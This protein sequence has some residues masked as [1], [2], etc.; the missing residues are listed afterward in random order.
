[1]SCTY[2][3]IHIAKKKMRLK[4]TNSCLSFVTTLWRNEVI[5]LCFNNLS[6]KIISTFCNQVMDS[7]DL[8]ELELITSEFIFFSY[9]NYYNLTKPI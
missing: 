7:K 3:D 6:K 8:R 4:N 5:M 1:M 9:S 2:I